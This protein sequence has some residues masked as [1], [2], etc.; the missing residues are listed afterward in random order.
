M[1]KLGSLVILVQGFDLSS[2]S[3]R[4]RYLANFRKAEETRLSAFERRNALTNIWSL[5]MPTRETW[6]KDI[7]MNWKNIFKDQI[8]KKNFKK[9]TAHGHLWRKWRLF[10]KTVLEENPI[11]KRPSRRLGRLDRKNIKKVELLMYSERWW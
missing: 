8:L 1:K 11:D 5:R 2:N 10:L 3:V 6:E 7:I 4:L 9:K